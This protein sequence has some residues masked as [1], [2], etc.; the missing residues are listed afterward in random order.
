M[1]WWMD[2]SSSSAVQTTLL[3]VVIFQKYSKIQKTPSYK[4]SHWNRSLNS[5][6]YIAKCLKWGAEICFS[7]KIPVDAETFCVGATKSNSKY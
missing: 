5:M 7:H 1:V 6:P 4:R 3:F 2:Y